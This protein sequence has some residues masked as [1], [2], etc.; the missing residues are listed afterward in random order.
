MYTAAELRKM[1]IPTT[2][3]EA[4]DYALDLSVTHHTHWW[5]IEHPTNSVSAQIGIVYGVCT[6]DD[7]AL[8]TS[9][10]AKILQ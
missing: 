6:E 7:K 5:A 9:E 2:A 10:G 3:D 1:H 8:Y 4:R